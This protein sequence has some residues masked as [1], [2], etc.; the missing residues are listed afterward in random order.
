MAYTSTIK[1]NNGQF[2]LCL[3]LISQIAK[4]MVDEG[5]ESEF[6]ISDRHH[7]KMPITIFR[8]SCRPKVSNYDT[9]INEMGA[10]IDVITSGAISLSFLSPDKTEHTT[11][12]PVGNDILNVDVRAI[13]FYHD[14]NTSAFIF[15]NHGIGEKVMGE[16]FKTLVDRYKI[17]AEL[18]I[19]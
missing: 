6:E 15:S 13:S 12:K 4:E 2:N 10:E 5:F 16:I 8:N 11:A 9:A 18:I 7:S 3:G 17:E 1:V 14:K 19:E